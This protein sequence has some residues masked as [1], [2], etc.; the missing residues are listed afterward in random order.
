MTLVVQFGAWAWA[1]EGRPDVVSEDTRR[2]ARGPGVKIAVAAVS[3]AVAAAVWLAVWPCF[4]VGETGTVPGGGSSARRACAT[5]IGVNGVWV[6]WLLLIP[7]AFT[8]LGLA[9][10]LVGRRR[11][12]WLIGGLAVGFCVLAVFSIGIFYLPSAIALLLAAGF[13]GRSKHVERSTPKRAGR[14]PQPQPSDP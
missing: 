9:A 6:V 4:Y 11:L 8:G 10:A 5:L 1:I 7:I 13:T 12:L 14:G 3:L 2:L